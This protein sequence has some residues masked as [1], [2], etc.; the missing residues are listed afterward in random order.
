LRA[1]L[2]AVLPQLGQLLALAQPLFCD[3]QIMPPCQV[4]Q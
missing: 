3:G 2:P 1:L 4:M